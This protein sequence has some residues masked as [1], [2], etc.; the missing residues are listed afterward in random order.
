[1]SDMHVSVLT[2]VYNG[3]QYL[4][5]CIEAVLAQTH[6]N[7][8]LTIVDNRST[9]ATPQIGQRFARADP[10]VRYE[11]HED[12]V[13]VT[14]NHNRA[15]RAVNPDSA[16]VKVAQADDL[17]FPDCL[18]RMV[19]LAVRTPTVGVVSGYRLCDSLVELVGL[20]FPQS[21]ASGR[22]ILRQSLLGGPYVTGSPNS[23]LYR[24]DLVRGRSPFFDPE[25]AHADTEA[26]YW[27]FTRADFALVHQVTTFS[28]R[29]PGSHNTRSSRVQS[30]WP[31]NMRMLLRYGPL[32]L[33]AEE[34]RSRLRYELSVYLWFHAKQRV[35]PSRWHDRDFHTFHRRMLRLLRGESRDDKDV[36]V[37]TAVIGAFLARVGEASG[38]LRTLDRVERRSRKSASCA[39]Y[40]SLQC[41]GGGEPRGSR[42]NARFG[43]RWLGR[44]SVDGGILTFGPVRWCRFGHF[45]RPADGGRERRA[46]RGSSTG[47][48]SR[49]LAVGDSREEIVG[50]PDR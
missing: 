42:S 20:P 14:E 3:E 50:A 46:H 8:T 9:D 12:F 28:R 6:R 16:Y 37:A 32:V 17:L 4:A 23:L 43:R 10:R 13:D 22:C 31:E 34:F 21:V 24:A 36:K 30:Y 7:L 48:T 47:R 49:L 33:S 1:M 39:S 27:A 29:Q 19:E 38:P 11:R 2:P 15:F 25:F 26:A 18:E 5:S 35:K 44:D 41:T 40:G 45:R